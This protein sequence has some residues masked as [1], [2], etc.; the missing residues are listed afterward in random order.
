MPDPSRGDAIDELETADLDNAM[1][2]EGIEPRGLG[3]EDN[4]A[5][6]CC[7]T[8]SSSLVVPGLEPGIQSNKLGV[9]CPGLP[10]QTR[11]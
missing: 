2:I 10:G 8:F 6:V 1:P 11:Q 7:S 5:Q 4:L 9:S 3:I